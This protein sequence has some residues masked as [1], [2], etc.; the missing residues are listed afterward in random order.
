MSSRICR[1]RLSR[2]RKSSGVATCLVALLAL[3]A[4]ED[5]TTG[6][7]PSFVM[8]RLM[9]AFATVWFLA[10]GVR[11]WKRRQIRCA[12]PSGPDS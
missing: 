11:T 9:V 12:A 1:G 7:E 6:V 8:E 10:V 3:L 2:V 5:I 4:L